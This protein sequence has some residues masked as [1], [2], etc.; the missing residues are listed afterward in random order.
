METFCTELELARARR[1]VRGTAAALIAA[2]V[3]TAAGFVAMCL[4]IRTKNAEMIHPWL[5]AVLIA[6]GWAC[7]LTGVY[8]LIPGR[9]RLAHLERIR[10]G[11]TETREGILQTVTEVFRVPK[12]I[13]ICRVTVDNGK[14]EPVRLSLD[15]QWISRMP[16]DGT[17]VRVT[18]SHSYI[19]GVETLAEAPGGTGKKRKGKLRAAIGKAAA[20]LPLLM[21][22]A[23]LGLLLGGFTW[24]RMTDTNAGHRILV[25]MDGE[26]ER[27]EEL[28][29]WMEKYLGEPIRKVKIHPFQYF[30][31]N[32]GELEQADLY[33]V[34]ASRTEGYGSWFAPLPEALQARDGVLVNEEGV[35]IGLPVYDPAG[36]IAVE[37]GTFRY[38]ADL[39]QEEVYYLLFGVKGAHQED[40]MALAAALLLLDE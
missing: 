22:W 36:D 25:C 8:G 10:E 11:E 33:I 7:I 30:L 19:T 18:V 29:A 35:P 40:G 2:A 39:G 37:E 20:V 15:E 21:I 27:E 31:F 9:A 1:R 3:L 34:P 4:C 32:T 26:T 24:H 17:E 28:A 14:D 16:P 6:G 38:G 13:R 12:S 5:I 23:F